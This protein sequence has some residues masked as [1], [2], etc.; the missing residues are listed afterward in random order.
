MDSSIGHA[1]ST[2]PTPEAVPPSQS[3][4]LQQSG[5]ITPHSGLLED[6]EAPS[7]STAGSD[8]YARSILPSPPQYIS[9]VASLSSFAEHGSPTGPPSLN[10]ASPFQQQPE[11]ADMRDSWASSSHIRARSTLPTPSAYSLQ[12]INPPSLSRSEASLYENE[13]FFRMDRVPTT[14]HNSQ[15]SAASPST[16]ASVGPRSTCPTPPIFQETQR[17]HPAEKGTAYQGYQLRDRYSSRWQG[18]E[19]SDDDD[20]VSIDLS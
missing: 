17:S 9:D 15:N 4:V 3:S 5:N 18:F 19:D 10:I 7:F 14:L 8:T 20:L 6:T 16:T 12:S 2:I 13:S 1:R 11:L